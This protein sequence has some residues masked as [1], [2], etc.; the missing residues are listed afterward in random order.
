MSW[1]DEVPV[2]V[3]LGAALVVCLLII[4]GLVWLLHDDRKCLEHGM[5]IVPIVHSDPK[6]HFT[7]IT[8]IPVNMCTKHEGDK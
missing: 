1:F 2:P 8:Y 5:V 7:W 3:L 6:T 4:G